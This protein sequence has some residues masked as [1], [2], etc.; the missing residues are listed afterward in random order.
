M[1]K[2]NH[3]GEPVVARHS[4]DG[5]GTSFPET[6][7][8]IFNVLILI[9]SLLILGSLSYDVISGR[10]YYLE[11]GFLFLQLVV[12]LIFMADFFVRLASAP[13]KRRYVARNWILLLVSVPLLNLMKWCDVELSRPWY[14]L[15]KVAPL[16][17]GFYGMVILVGWVTRSRVRNLFYS[18]LLTVVG[19]TYFAALI[20]Y[21]FERGINPR[22][23]SFGDALWWAWMNVTTVGAELF[24][25]TA[26]GKILSVILPGLGMMMFPI[27]TVYVT[28]Y[29][30][31]T[32]SSRE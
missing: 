30:R 27:F 3:I 21:S 26:I 20:F 23:D 2:S 6:A 19:F 22:L 18:Y 31:R 10:Q 17:R 5:D 16:L 29:F 8:R 32:R 11:P 4:A 14:I 1:K 25:V 15:F 28:D 13:D 9:G 12:C 24:A 7:V